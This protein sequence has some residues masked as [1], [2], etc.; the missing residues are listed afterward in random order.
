MLERLGDV[1]NTWS[2]S[3]IDEAAL[4]RVLVLIGTHV[5]DHEDRRHVVDMLD[6][7]QAAQRLAR[8]DNHD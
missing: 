2:T 6:L 4:R 7:T 5:H 3:G 8:G 1:F